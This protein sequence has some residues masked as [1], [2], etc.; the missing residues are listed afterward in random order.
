MKRLLEQE[1]SDLAAQRLTDLVRGA[2]PF[3]L[4][5]FRKRQIWVQL[6]SATARKTRRPPWVL[7]ALGA[8]VLLIGGSAA[9]ALGWLPGMGASSVE[10]EGAPA[11]FGEPALSAPRAESKAPPATSDQPTT[12]EEGEPTPTRLDDTGSTT[13][14][15]ATQLHR[16]TASDASSERA[17]TPS[18]SSGEDPAQ[19]LAA[20]RAWRSEHDANKAR[21]LLSAYLRDNPRGALTE[22]ALALLIEVA[23]AQR[24]PRASDYARR[25]L[26][27]YP[28]GRYRAMATRVVE[29]SAT[30]P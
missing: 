7:A 17:K 22:D 24:D 14:A 19:V 23:A 2:R 25:Y 5:P 18:S 1:P 15:P 27:A 12:P 21:R 20:I 4:N 3:E 28:R 6:T 11:S 8:G 26:T 9:A 13:P 30:K 16:S 29:A 10:E